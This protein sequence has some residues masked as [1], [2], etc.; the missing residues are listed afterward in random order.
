MHREHAFYLWVVF[1][2]H[3][4]HGTGK[5]LVENQSGGFN[6]NSNNA[7]INPLNGKPID[8]W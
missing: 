1:H 3:L 2:E 7:P 4:G 8:S 5:L 6:F